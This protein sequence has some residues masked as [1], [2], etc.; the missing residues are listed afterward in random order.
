M[1]TDFY[2]DSCGAGQIHGCRWTPEGEILAVLQVVHGIAEHIERYDAFA[3]FLNAHGVL[4]VGEDHMGH[5]GSA[6]H[7]GTQGHFD[8]GWDAVVTDT[9]QLLKTT[10][11]EFPDKPYFLFGHSMGS[12]LSRTIL[13]KYPDLGL[14]GCVI[15]GTGWMPE[16][17]VRSGHLAAKTCC[18]MIG[19]RTPSKKLE[20]MTFGG[21]NKRVEHQRTDSDWLTRDSAVVDAYLADPRDGFTPS[22]GLL[23]DMLGGMIYNQKTEHLKRMDPALPILFVA[24]GDDPVGS[25]GKGVQQTAEKFRQVGV[26]DVTCKLFPLC[27][28]EILNEL[29]RQEIFGYIYNWLKKYA[30][31]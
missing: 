23:R 31:I 24:G 29:N 19:E 22:C 7:G 18:A 6:Q 15:C 30:E 27:R 2:Y 1:R 9:V 8:G 4:V 11:Q 21:F 20:K 12:F 13:C 3:S 10:K 25:Y 14:T 17:V 26:Q 5:G 16:A 28:H